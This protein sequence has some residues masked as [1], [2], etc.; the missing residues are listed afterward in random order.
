MNHDAELI[1]PTALAILTLVLR[2]LRGVIALL[3]PI[4]LWRREAWM[5]IKCSIA[6]R[7]CG[8]QRIITTKTSKMSP[9]GV[10]KLRIF[11]QYSGRQRLRFWS[12]ESETAI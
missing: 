3:C 4:E 5:G 9:V 1:N 11:R 2:E 10:K 12:Y 6:Q 8:S 7:R